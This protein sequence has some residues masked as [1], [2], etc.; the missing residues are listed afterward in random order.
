MNRML[1]IVLTLILANCHNDRAAQQQTSSAA[2]APVSN[3]ETTALDSDDRVTIYFP[4]LTAKTGQQICVD[5]KVRNFNQILS[6]QYTVAWNKAIL[7]F[8]ELR[9]FK[10][11]YL[12]AGDFGQ[13]ITQDGLLTTAWLDDS[14][15]SVTLSD[16]ASIY[17]ICFE[18]IGKAG[19]ESYLKITDRPTAIEVAN[20]KEQ[21]IPLKKENGS[22]KVIE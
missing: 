21:L 1:L 12:D 14:L 16:G 13:H 4:N 6:M 18:V 17:Q 3:T 8:K 19:E 10:L 15:K 11:A 9:N 20:V 2:S 22:V 7:K 5:I